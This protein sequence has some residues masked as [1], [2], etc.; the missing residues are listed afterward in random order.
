MPTF[1]APLRQKWRHLPPR[2]QK[3]LLSLGSFL[4]LVLV[5]LL[6]WQ[7]QRQALQDAERHYQDELQLR[8][9]LSSLPAARAVPQG[10]RV[11]AEALP[12]FLTRTSA[13]ADLAIERMNND[14]PGRMSL[15][16][17]GKL[18]S[19]VAWLERLESG[20][21]AVTSLGLEVSPE[22]DVRA[23]LVVEAG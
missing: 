23:R 20:G 4:G 6:L 8:L 17:D 21:V 13:D 22:A 3:A 16:L 15:S 14:G 5:W 12:G 1:I 19:L 11:E 2:E 10:E 18:A 7:P 9:D